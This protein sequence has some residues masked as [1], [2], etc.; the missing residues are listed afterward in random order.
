MSRDLPSQTRP[1]LCLVLDDLGF[2]EANDFGAL[3]LPRGV[4]LSILP[5]G[6]HAR[7]LA[8]EARA[9]GHEVFLHMPM[10]PLGAADP[11][12]GALRLDLSWQENVARVAAALEVI[13]PVF[14][15][16]NHMG[17]AFTENEEALR[18]IMTFLSGRGLAFVDS[19]TSSRSCAFRVAQS[20]GVRA[21]ENGAF[22]DNKSDELYL[23][24]QMNMAG[25]KALQKGFIVGIAHAHAATIRALPE[26]LR[27]LED[28][29]V[30]LSTVEDALSCLNDVR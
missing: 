5:Y 26:C 24:A 1:R 27:N 7:R 13:G 18:P 9:L 25:Q 23:P 22:L 21:L 16:N 14:G 19:R 4:T 11:G 8:D 6:S 30:S 20:C 3:T 12:P 15:V 10:Q 28:Q 17:S 29:G 2:N